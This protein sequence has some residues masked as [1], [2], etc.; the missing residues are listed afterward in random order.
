MQEK[1]GFVYIWF[2]RKHKRFY[3]GCRWGHENDGYICSSKWMKKAYKIRPQDFKRRILYRIYTNRKELLEQEFKWLSL[4][5]PYELHGKYYNLYNHHFNH[6]ATNPEQSK[7]IAEKISKKNKGK[8]LA[9]DVEGNT[10]IIYK[11]DPRW[12]NG[13]LVGVTT[14]HT[15]TEEANSKRSKTMT[16]IIHSNEMREKMRVA[17]SGRLPW[18]TGKKLT[19]EQLQKKKESRERNKKLGITKNKKPLT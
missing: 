6:W 7:I 16:G 11:D 3:I 2:D 8:I 4:I 14:G 10:H 12:I 9:K 13:E 18:N 17:M 15:Q 5:K 1:Y 19:A